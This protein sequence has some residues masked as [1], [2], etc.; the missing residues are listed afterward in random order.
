MMHMAFDW[1]DSRHVIMSMRWQAWTLRY[2]L[3][4]LFSVCCASR[5]DALYTPLP[6]SSELFPVPLGK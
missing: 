6:A 1:S 5:F 2:F 3:F 4:L